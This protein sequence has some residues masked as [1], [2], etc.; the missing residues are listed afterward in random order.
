M[1][2]TVITGKSLEAKKTQHILRELNIDLTLPAQ[3]VWMELSRRIGKTFKAEV[4]ERD[5]Y[6]NIKKFHAPGADTTGKTEVPEQATP[7]DE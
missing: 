6:Y 5:G 4:F 7:T 1:R 3:E 2:G